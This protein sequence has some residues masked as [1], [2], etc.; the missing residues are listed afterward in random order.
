MFQ[1]FLS[2][3]F[4]LFF[5]EK[6]KFCRFFH[7]FS[8]TANENL[9]I[10]FNCYG[11]FYLFCTKLILIFLL[12]FFLVEDVFFFFFSHLVFFYLFSSNYSKD[13]GRIMSPFEINVACYFEKRIYFF[14]PLC[15][16]FCFRQSITKS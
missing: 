7:P 9:L 14:F 1:R 12:S 5:T 15:K 11:C 4:C 8:V 10:F 3:C 13:K 6:S 16:L 2:Q